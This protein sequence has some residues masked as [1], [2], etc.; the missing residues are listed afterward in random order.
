MILNKR[1]YIFILNKSKIQDVIKSKPP[2]GVI[3]INSVFIIWF[4]SK[5]ALL[6][7]IIY[8]ENENRNVPKVNNKKGGFLIK[9]D[10]F[11]IT[12]TINPKLFINW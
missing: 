8:R 3:G 11:R 5:K 4:V 9:L 10:L 12:K 6:K 7:A 2:K 1:F